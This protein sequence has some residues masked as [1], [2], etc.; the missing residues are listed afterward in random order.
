MTYGQKP[1][2]NVTPHFGVDQRNLPI[3]RLLTQDINLFAIVRNDQVTV[4]P[5]VQFEKIFLYDVR[6]VTQAQYEIPM[7]VLT[8][9]MHD[10]SQDR[11]LAHRNHGLGNALGIFSNPS[12]KATAEQHDLHPT[13]L[14]E[15]NPPDDHY[16]NKR[17]N[18]NQGAAK[19]RW[20]L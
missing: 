5:S 17:S 2:T 14:S 3:R 15:D 18:T 1:L 16:Q 10:M 12:P 8:V 11:L 7:P 4:G 13:E 9:I 20:Y 19:I 6:L